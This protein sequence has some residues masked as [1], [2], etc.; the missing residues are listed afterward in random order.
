MACTWVSRIGNNLGHLCSVDTNYFDKCKLH[1]SCHCYLWT[2]QAKPAYFVAWKLH[3][4]GK[5]G[6]ARQRLSFRISKNSTGNRHS[7]VNGFFIFSSQLNNWTPHRKSTNFSN[8]R[9]S[10]F[11]ISGMFLK[12]RKS[13]YWWKIFSIHIFV[14]LLEKFEDIW[15]MFLSASNALSIQF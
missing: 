5:C 1:K 4:C 7:S 12:S 11:E 6:T 3:N 10:D 13:G 14:N 15:D 8:L 9:M 2:S